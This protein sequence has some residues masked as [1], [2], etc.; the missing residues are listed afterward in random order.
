MLDEL[1]L[2]LKFNTLYLE[3]MFMTLFIL[4]NIFDFFILTV[5]NWII[6]TVKYTKPL[7]RNVLGVLSFAKEKEKKCKECKRKECIA[8]EYKSNPL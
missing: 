7:R 1:C 8:E 5:M 2:C 6:T 4:C 3:N